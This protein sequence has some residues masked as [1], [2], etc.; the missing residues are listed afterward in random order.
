MVYNSHNNEFEAVFALRCYEKLGH[1]DDQITETTGDV[2]DPNLLPNSLCPSVVDA[3]LEDVAHML[4]ENDV[5]A[6]NLLRFAQNLCDNNGEY[7]YNINVGAMLEYYE[8]SS[9]SF[10]NYDRIGAITAIWLLK[11]TRG[12]RRPFKN[13]ESYS[14]K[15]GHLQWC[16]LRM[17]F[18]DYSELLPDRISRSIEESLMERFDYAWYDVRNFQKERIQVFLDILHTYSFEYYPPYS[19]GEIGHRGEIVN[20]DTTEGK[21]KEGSFP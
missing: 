5:S 15:I 20:N 16:L 21:T 9:P 11:F 13:L 2:L 3:M 7:I 12:T 8:N 1:I 17:F 4:P 10:K 6:M 19:E 18:M 14:K